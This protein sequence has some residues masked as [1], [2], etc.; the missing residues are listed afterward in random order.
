MDI[1]KYRVHVSACV[2]ICMC[3]CVETEHSVDKLSTLPVLLCFH[4][5]VTLDTPQSGS[6]SSSVKGQSGLFQETAPT[7]SGA[8]VSPASDC[9]PPSHPWGGR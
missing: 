5:L 1:H 8:S 2:C 7:S 4:S 3:V 9:C 6:V